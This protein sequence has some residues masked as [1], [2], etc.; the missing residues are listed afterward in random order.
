MFI[1]VVNKM[2]KVTSGMDTHKYLGRTLPANLRDRTATEL[3]QRIR[4]AWQQFHEHRHALTDQNVSVR[5]RLKLFQSVI[6]PTLFFGLACLPLTKQQL[7]SLDV[8]QNK[9]L[10][11]I[12]GWR[13]VDGEEWAD[14]MRR[15]RDRVNDALVHFPIEC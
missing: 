2:L 14:T 3:G 6:T 10:R 9:M 13:R 15:M 7:G 12:V 5:L 1:E 8:S 11:L 4:R